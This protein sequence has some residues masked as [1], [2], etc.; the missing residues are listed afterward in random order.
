MDITVEGLIKILKKH[1]PKAKIKVH[2][3]TSIYDT[4]IKGVNVDEYEK[5]QGRN[6][7]RITV[8]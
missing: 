4:H 8:S 2:E 7:V 5:K 1:D 3:K 6:V